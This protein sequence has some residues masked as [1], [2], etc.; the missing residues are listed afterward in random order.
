MGIEEADVWVPGQVLCQ[1][2]GPEVMELRLTGSLQHSDPDTS[3]DPV[4]GWAPPRT[5]DHSPVPLFTETLAESTDMAVRKP[6]AT[7]CFRWGH[8]TLVQF[9]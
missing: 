8:H 3:I 2:C 1:K 4:V 5:M 6:E 7:S 9:A